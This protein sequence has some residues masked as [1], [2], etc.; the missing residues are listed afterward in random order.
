MN[1]GS[2]RTSLTLFNTGNDVAS[3]SAASALVEEMQT[4]PRL[5]DLVVIYQLLLD[6]TNMA[7]FVG[8]KS[9]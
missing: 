1:L 3:N 7:S 8:S 2:T 6:P 5:W 9:N 4:R